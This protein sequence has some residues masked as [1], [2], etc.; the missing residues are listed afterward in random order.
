MHTLQC[1][2]PVLFTVD[3]NNID[4][5]PYIFVSRLAIHPKTWK[6]SLVRL[7]TTNPHNIFQKLNLA[8]WS[9]KRTMLFNISNGRSLHLGAR[10]HGFNQ[11]LCR[12]QY[13][14]PL[15][16]ND[17][18]VRPTSKLSVSSGSSRQ[19]LKPTKVLALSIKYKCFNTFTVMSGHITFWIHNVVILSLFR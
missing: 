5:T 16:V 12:Q 8:E 1:R 19:Q 11:E 7:T 4:C 6:F 15:S 3:I 14:R 9:D 13:N 2:C 10:Y 18:G 17:L